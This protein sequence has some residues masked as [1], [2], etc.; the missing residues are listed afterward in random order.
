MERRQFPLDWKIIVVWFYIT[1]WTTYGTEV[2]ASFAA[3]YKDPVKD[4][5]RAL[6]ASAAMILGIYL[7]VPYV[8]VGALGEET[9]GANR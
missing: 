4:T 5:S 3:E 1:A 8:V 9:I 6:H 2:C 7:V